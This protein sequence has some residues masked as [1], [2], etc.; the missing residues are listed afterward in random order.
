M[1]DALIVFVFYLSI[2]YQLYILYYIVPSKWITII[3][4]YLLHE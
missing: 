1:Y 2:I 4:E 3:C